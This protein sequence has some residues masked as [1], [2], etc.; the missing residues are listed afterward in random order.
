MILSESNHLIIAP[1]EDNNVYIWQ[2]GKKL[3]G[4]SKNNSYEFFKPFNDDELTNSVFVTELCLQDYISKSFLTAK[5]IQVLSILIN[6]SDKG[7]IQVLLNYRVN[8]AF[9]SSEI[10]K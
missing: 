5:S 9:K 10:K 4:C 1:S 6:T 3:N 7:K 8:Q 2:S